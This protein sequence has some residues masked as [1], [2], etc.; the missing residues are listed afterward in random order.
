[1]STA[2]V[3]GLSATVLFLGMRWLSARAEVSELLAQ[4][5]LLKR[6]LARSTR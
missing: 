3:I 6:R 2:I 1:V 4:I 5:A